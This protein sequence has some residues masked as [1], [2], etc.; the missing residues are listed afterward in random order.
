MK[1]FEILLDGTHQLLLGMY[2]FLLQ[3][4]PSFF[5]FRYRKQLLGTRF[6]TFLQGECRTAVLLRNKG[7]SIYVDS[8]CKK[9]LTMLHTREQL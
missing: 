2:Q 9:L 1:T 4:Y 5:K 6:V 8:M 3:P 7:R